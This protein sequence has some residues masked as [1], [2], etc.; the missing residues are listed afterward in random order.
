MTA[1]RL[2]VLAAGPSVTVQDRGR[3]GWQRFGVT[4]G[5]ALDR[6]GLAEG[7]AL[8]GLPPEAAAL[9]MIGRGG[10]FRVEGRPLVLALSGAPFKASLDGAPL[11][12]RG[13]FV[14][15][16]GQVLEI[17]ACLGAEVGYLTPGGTLDLPRALGARATHLR[18]GFGGLE[19]RALRAGDALSVLPLA[20]ARP[21]LALPEP[22]HLRPPEPAEIRVL[23]GPQAERFSAAERRRFVETRFTVTARRDRMGARLDSAA[24]PLVAEGGLSGL[25]DAVSLGDL[26]VPGDGRP[27]VLLADRQPTGGYPR[28]ATVIGADLARFVQLSTGRSV[29]F[30]PVEEAEALDALRAWRAA[31]AALP[32]SVGPR[33]RDPRD[34]DDLLAYDLISGA[35]DGADPQD[36][37]EERPP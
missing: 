28:I 26:Q 9:E 13:S 15:A 21:G 36:P 17:G 22:E 8:L 35:T 5:G 25:S 7:Q 19:G 6:F 23:W 29:G 31:L 11:A 30:R 18:A 14:L 1:A 37:G 12:W 16:P 27:L 20:R 24:P 4:E 3:P 10:R 34:M 33:L 2:E 32:R